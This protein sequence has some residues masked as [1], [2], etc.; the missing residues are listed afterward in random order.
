MCV[1]VG[2]GKVRER[3]PPVN[4]HSK[5]LSTAR[6]HLSLTLCDFSSFSSEKLLLSAFSFY[7]VSVFM[8]QLLDCETRLKVLQ[9][10]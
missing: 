7:L 9:T 6:L 1:S 10:K 4:K 5:G 3:S 2:G 8:Q